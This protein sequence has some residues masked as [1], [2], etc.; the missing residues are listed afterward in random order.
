L[1]A[2]G[3]L[4]KEDPKFSTNKPGMVVLIYNPNYMGGIGRRIF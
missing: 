3:R 4:R 1:L 2:L